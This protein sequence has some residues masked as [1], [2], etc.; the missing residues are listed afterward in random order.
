ML[1]TTTTTTTK[2]QAFIA[3]VALYIF[4]RICSFQLISLAQQEQRQQQNNA[5]TKYTSGQKYRIN[6]FNGI[7]GVLVLVC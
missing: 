3:S 6:L 7:C 5:H 2:D 1:K 4:A